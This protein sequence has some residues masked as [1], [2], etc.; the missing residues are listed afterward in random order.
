MDFEEYKKLLLDAE[1][2]FKGEYVYEFTE[3]AKQRIKELY[4]NERYK[5]FRCALYSR[6][7]EIYVYVPTTLE[8]K[9][10]AWKY[11][12]VADTKEYNK[13]VQNMLKIFDDQINMPVIESTT[14]SMASY[15]CD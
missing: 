15:L 13:G 10:D 3:F 14:L 8:N 1:I 5:I 9:N 11:V 4:S 7:D 2:I 12:K 6:N